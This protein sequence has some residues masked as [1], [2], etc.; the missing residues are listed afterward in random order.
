[1]RGLFLCQPKDKQ[2]RSEND[3]RQCCFFW[4]IWTEN[5]RNI[6]LIE[7]FP[8]NDCLN[9]SNNITQYGRTIQTYEV[10]LKR[11]IEKNKNRKGGAEMHRLWNKKKIGQSLIKLLLEFLNSKTR[12]EFSLKNTRACIERRAHSSKYSKNLEDHS[13]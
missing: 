11:R 8:C 7:L 1:M 2:W 12:W 6:F 3:A 13:F 4:I 9:D 5:H 10:R